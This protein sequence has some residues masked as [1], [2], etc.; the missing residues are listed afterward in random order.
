VGTPRTRLPA[1]LLRR[2]HFWFTTYKGAVNAELFI[3]LLKNMM[4]EGRSKPVHLVVGGLPAHK[5]LNVREYI[6]S[7]HGKLT[8]HVLPGYAPD[9]NSDELVWSH[10][11][12]S[13]VAGN[14]LRAGEKLELRIEQPLHDVQKNR[15][16]V[17]SFFGTPSV[18]C[19][20]DC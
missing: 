17:R 12:R 8:M 7:T 16:L 18:A 10:V 2:L 13:G 9:L 3:D 4:M 20:S 1:T 19:I 15:R 6:A 11:V 5:K 14:P